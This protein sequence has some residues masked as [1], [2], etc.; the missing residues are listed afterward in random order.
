MV[1]L[2]THLVKTCES[3]SRTNEFQLKKQSVRNW[4][5]LGLYVTRQ[6]IW[7]QTQKRILH[8]TLKLK[9]S[10]S[11]SKHNVQSKKIYSLLN[12][13]HNDCHRNYTNRP[14]ILT[15]TH[16]QIDWSIFASY[17]MHAMDYFVSLRIFCVRD[18]GHRGKNITAYNVLN[19]KTGSIFFEIQRT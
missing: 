11:V 7:R 19:N 3:Q 15:E 5:C 13:N 8:S 4:K 10:P 17:G 16:A 14:E 6:F 1:S 12:N 2:G 18:A 9:Y